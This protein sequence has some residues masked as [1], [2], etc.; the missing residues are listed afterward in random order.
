MKSSLWIL[1]LALAGSSSA[2]PTFSHPDR[3]KYDGH[4]FTIDGKDT[5]IFSGAFH[6]FR[7]PKELWRDRFK[8]IK[9]AGFNAVETYVAWNW[10]EQTRPKDFNDMS[11]IHLKDLDE[12]LDMAEKEFGLYT[13]VRPGPYIC[14]EW[15]SGGFPNW[16]QTF[17][18]AKTKRSLWYRSDDPVF[19][20][21]SD[22]W[23]KAV[24]KV[25]DR[26]QITKLK[27]GSKGMILWQVENEYDYSS[28]SDETKR[29]YT[30]Y[31]IQSSKNHGIE[32][33]I[34]TC[35]TNPVRYPKGDAVLS[36]AFDN[37]NE[38]VRWNIQDAVNAINAQQKAQ[39]WAPKMITEFQGG[40]FG[41]VGGLAAEEQ[42]GITD[43]QIKA[44]TIWTIAN[45]LTG[46][47]Y[48]ML[49]GGTNFGDWAGQGITTCYDYYCPIREWGGVGSKFRAVKAVGIMLTNHGDELARSVEVPSSRQQFGTVQSVMRRGSKGGNYIF[50]WNT[51]RNESGV[52]TPGNGQQVTVPAFGSGIYWYQS[53]PSDGKWLVSPA[54]DVAPRV[55]KPTSV[56]ISS[57]SVTNLTP[58]GWRSAPNVPS[59]T[60]LGIWDSRFVS[61]QIQVPKDKYLWLRTNNSELV[62]NSEPV[63]SG[64]RGGSAWK[65]D[66]K[67]SQFV[68]F[69]PGWPN[70]GPG[71]EDPHGIIAARVLDKA[72]D[73]AGIQGWRMKMLSDQDDRSLVAEGV[74]TSAWMKGVD[75]NLFKS[76]MTGVIRA[77]VD[78][79]VT[80]KPETVLNCGG[81]DDE[82]WFYV[83]GHLVG[84]IHTWDVP[85]SLK[86]G[87][88]LH[89]G[90]NDIAIVIR[91]N[92]GPGGLTGA[93]SIDMPLPKSSQPEFR[94]TD[95]YKSGAYKGYQLNTRKALVVNEHPK[96][97][98]LRPKGSAKLVRSR[99]T[100]DLP[101][102]KKIWQMLIDAG[103]DGFLTLNGHA[104]G[105][106]WE[107]GPQRA[108]FLPGPWLKKHNVLE[109]T[110]VPGRLGDR[111]KAAELQS[112]PEVN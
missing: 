23:Y 90:R 51:S 18:P 57:A 29:N 98:G 21:W 72:P 104:L 105:R 92:D 68:L 19:E 111:I 61:Y 85:V 53:D 73:A 103:G 33:P 44:L 52:V 81:V 96:I 15:A 41:G 32:V 12:W 87:K 2:Q 43:S 70:G 34:F 28:L 38:Y 88:F 16:L 84:E 39:P 11:N 27:P 24:A 80:P 37:P 6:Y 79:A 93:V 45:G 75:N 30:K 55:A 67:T 54:A 4:C 42:D 77:T 110:V 17:R 71:M 26:H 10:S 22:R 89:K 20:A 62:G 86:V 107:V 65:S 69:N 13:I 48:Y 64:I 101:S 95:Q 14:S 106:Y 9:E 56:R 99:I 112:L 60:A 7:C 46:L 100:F 109:L 5:F 1:A 47:N 76:H 97:E 82:G 91:N 8:R 66:G 74:D 36:Q 49:F 58:T 59:T 63:G 25:V 83:N 35:W 94:W 108:F 40:W 50:F 3:I 31:L 78:F 102:N